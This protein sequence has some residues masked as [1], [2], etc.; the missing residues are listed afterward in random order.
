MIPLAGSFDHQRGCDQ[1]VENCYPK[2]ASETKEEPR[3]SQDAHWAI[4]A[5][6]RCAV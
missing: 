5:K 3:G 1:Q 2:V 4:R 6:G